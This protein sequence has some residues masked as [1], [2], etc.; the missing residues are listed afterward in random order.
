MSE[1]RGATRLAPAAHVSCSIYLRESSDIPA[2]IVNISRGGL[3][4]RLKEWIDVRLDD[5]LSIFLLNTTSSIELR[6]D[7]TVR[8]TQKVDLV[9]LLIGVECLDLSLENLDLM[10][11][12]FGISKEFVDPITGLS[13]LA[14]SDS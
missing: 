13:W 14:T 12:L 9:H 1:S 4:L 7:A 11:S 8:W 10:C 2:D 3:C 6:V 5:N